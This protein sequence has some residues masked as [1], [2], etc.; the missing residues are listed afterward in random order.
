MGKSGNWRMDLRMRLIWGGE[1]EAKSM[2]HCTARLAS[3]FN[4]LRLFFASE[5]ESVA[6]VDGGSGTLAIRRPR[7]RVWRFRWAEATGRC[8]WLWLWEVVDFVVVCFEVRRWWWSGRVAPLR[9]WCNHGN[10]LRGRN[11]CWVMCAS[12]DMISENA[13][14]VPSSVFPSSRLL[15]KQSMQPGLNR[16]KNNSQLY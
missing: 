4:W 3:R 13:M 6:A 14:P 10:D 1:K 9:W 16:E 15:A 8:L 11:S 12:V 5:S 7:E 2:P